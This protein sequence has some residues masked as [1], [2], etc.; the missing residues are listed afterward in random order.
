MTGSKVDPSSFTKLMVTVLEVPRAGG[1]GGKVPAGKMKFSSLYLILTPAPGVKLLQTF[2]KIQK[3]IHA[4]I[5]ATK[6]GLN[7][8]KLQ[9]NGAYFNA[10]DNITECLKLLEDAINSSGCNS[11]EHT[12]ATIGFNSEPEAYYNSEQNKYD[13]EG[14]KNLFD[15]GMFVDWYIKLL[16]DHPLVSYLE[17]PFAEKEGYQL[18]PQKLQE[19]GLDQRVKFGLRNFHKGNLETLKIH[20]EFIEKEEEDEAEGEEEKKEEAPEGEGEQPAEEEKKETPEGEGEGD[21]EPEDPNKD[22]FYANILHVD[23]THYKL[24]SDFLD[25]QSYGNTQKGERKQRVIIQDNFY[26]SSN[27]DIID[28]ALGLNAAYVNIKGINN[29]T[30]LAKVLRYNTVSSR[31]LKLADSE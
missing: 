5:N 19:A 27:S 31:L 24:F 26:E 29:S 14:P 2:V 18:L 22:K 16:N 9:G 28:L 7:G 23:R 13:I 6:V 3:A 12:V 21:K 4:N 11:D 1:A 10:S 17:D 30:K 20:T 25:F 15:A 8:Y